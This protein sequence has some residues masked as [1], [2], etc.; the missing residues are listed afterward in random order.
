MPGARH[1]VCP[2]PVTRAPRKVTYASEALAMA[3]AR[4]QWHSGSCRI[5]SSLYKQVLKQSGQQGS[6][7]HLW[8]HRLQHWLYSQHCRQ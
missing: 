1:M 7:L 2:P 4:L 8:M 5:G 6:L 3:T